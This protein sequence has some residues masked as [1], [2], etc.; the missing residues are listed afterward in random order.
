MSVDNEIY[1][2]P[3][4]IWW[5]EHQPLNAI[6]T[7]INPARLDYFTR[8]LREMKVDPAGKTVVDIGC[9][10]GF[11]LFVAQAFGHRGLG[12]DI[13]RRIVEERHAGTITIDSHPGQT[14]LRVSLPVGPSEPRGRTAGVGL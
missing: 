7:A 6:R 3:G 12:L 4:D 14:V 13:A 9:G 2:R 10:G 5:D 8:V 11:F 1:N